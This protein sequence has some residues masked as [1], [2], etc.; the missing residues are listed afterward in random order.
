VLVLQAPSHV[1][2]SVLDLGDRD[3][4]MTEDRAAALAEWY[5][6]FRDDILAFIDPAT[7]DRAVVPG[8]IELPPV[9]GTQYVAGVDPSGGSSD[10]MTLSIA[11]A[12][13]ERGILDLARQWCAPFNPD[14]VCRE[15]AEI[16]RRCGITTVTGD[17]YA[18]EWCA[19][20]F[21]STGLTI[22]LPACRGA[23]CT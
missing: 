22:S 15:I 10:S 6:E 5:A 14:Q 19:S 1:L 21:A 18:G 11:H 2:N 17:R 8:R 20:D 9:A 16:C 4:A 13:G 3:R 12:D 23:T 7:V